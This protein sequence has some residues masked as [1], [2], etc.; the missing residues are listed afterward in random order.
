[1]RVFLRIAHSHGT[2]NHTMFII[3]IIFII[4]SPS[5]SSSSSSS[6]SSC[7]FART[8]FCSLGKPQRLAVVSIT[9]YFHMFFLSPVQS[10]TSVC[11]AGLFFKVLQAVFGDADMFARVEWAS[12]LWAWQIGDLPPYIT[13]KCGINR[14]KRGVSKEM[15]LWM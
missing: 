2:S 6:S 5:P 14:I 13:I 9:L 15:V 10:C 8:F 7:R 12:R 11:P 4:S 1:M 3:F